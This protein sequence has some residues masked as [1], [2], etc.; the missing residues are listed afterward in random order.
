MLTF[1]HASRQRPLLGGYLSHPAE[2]FPSV[3]GRSTFLKANPYA[4]PCLIGALFP[5]FGALLGIFFLEETLK[6]TRPIAVDP[7]DPEEI[8]DEVRGIHRRD[9]SKHNR[10]VAATSTTLPAPREQLRRLEEDSEGPDSGYSTPRSASVAGRLGGS[11]AKLARHAPPTFRSMFTRR[12]NAALGV[13]AM[14]A[15]IT[16]ALD[17]SSTSSFVRRTPSDR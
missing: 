12:V 6:P 17:V 7:T 8:A 5:F 16:V 3:F 15:L 11:P 4:L 14:L 2:Q 13:Y 1:T 9:A 10:F